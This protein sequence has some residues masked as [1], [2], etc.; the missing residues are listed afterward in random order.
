VNAGQ[1]QVLVQTRSTDRRL[2]AEERLA[3]TSF[4]LHQAKLEALIGIRYDPDEYDQL[5]LAYRDARRRA[6]AMRRV[7]HLMHLAAARQV[8]TSVRSSVCTW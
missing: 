4:R 8:Q 7:S 5:V 6:D 1:D 2:H 3:D